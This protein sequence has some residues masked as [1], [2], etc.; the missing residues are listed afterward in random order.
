MPKQPLASIIIP[1]YNRAHLIVETLDSI[2]QQS[3]LNWEC[4]VVDD[5]STDTT[6]EVITSYAEKDSRIKLYKRPDTKPK[7]ANAC[8]NIGLDKAQGNY[9]VFFD[10]DD[11]MTE[12][13]LEV[14][15]NAIQKFD[16]DYVLTKTQYFN[17]S[18]EGIN[19][20]Y[21]F[22]T[23]PITA[24][25][26][27][28]RKINWLTLDV[29]IKATLAKSI[30]FNENLQSGQEYNYFSKL[31]HFSTNTEFIDEVISLRRY[32]NASIRARLNNGYKKQVGRFRASWFTYLDLKPIAN[33]DSLEFLMNNCVRVC[34]ETKSVFVATKKLFVKE[35]LSFYGLRGVYFLLLFFSLK[36]L[37]LGYNYRHLFLK[38]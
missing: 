23:I 7:G 33:N 28:T 1:V 20:Y 18:N 6:V 34:H 27:V 25:N 29:C 8:R 24:Y 37:K 3:Y 30:S 16:C 2:M 11:L 5:V 26:Y 10:S 32:H 22:D 38:D 31:V 15:V 4:L 21:Q 14:K 36:Y 12:N 9:I 19:A 17:Y 13:H 35:V